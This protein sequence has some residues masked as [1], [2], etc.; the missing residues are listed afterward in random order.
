MPILESAWSV[1]YDF[2]IEDNLRD[3]YLTDNQIDGE[4]L[5][6]AKK[7]SQ[8][9]TLRK[10]DGIQ[11][12]SISYHTVSYVKLNDPKFTDEKINIAIMAAVNSSS[13]LGSE[14]A[15][16][17]LRHLTKGNR[18]LLFISESGCYI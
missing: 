13:A 10:F 7:Y 8:I 6:L 4:L 5:H 12:R 16:R 11:K 15:L 17:F 9:V 2:D 3:I 18:M 14:I 1:T